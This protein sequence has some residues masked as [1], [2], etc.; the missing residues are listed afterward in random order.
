MLE[1]IQEKGINKMNEEANIEEIFEKHNN[2]FLEFD[3]VE[4]KRSNRPDL[5][6]FILLDE[7]FPGDRDLISSAEHDEIWLDITTEDIGNLTEDQIIEL[8][9]CGVRY[10][11]EALCMFV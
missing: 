7:L 10:D 2:E 5:H 3:R 1:W 9:R 4:N 8:V 11:E 6:A